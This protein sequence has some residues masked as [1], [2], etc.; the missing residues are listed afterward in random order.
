MKK[1]QVGDLI[2]SKSDR[3]IRYVVTKVRTKDARESGGYV[4]TRANGTGCVLSMLA[5]TEF[6]LLT[7]DESLTCRLLKID[8]EIRRDQRIRKE[9]IGD[10]FV[11][12]YAA[13]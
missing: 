13:K 12:G 4:I 7:R 5:A 6:E 10:I 8:A 11:G 2:V 1:F 3:R 9:V